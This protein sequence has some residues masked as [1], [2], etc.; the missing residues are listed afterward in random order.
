MQQLECLVTA[1]MQDSML[2]ADSAANKLPAEEAQEKAQATAKKGKKKKQTPKKLYQV[3]SAA[4]SFC[5]CLPVLECFFKSDMSILFQK[6]PIYDG[7]SN[8][9]MHIDSNNALLHWAGV[10]CLQRLM[11]AAAES[12]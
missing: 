3:A 9:E 10:L 7:N 4:Q 6:R 1:P 2:A 12:I 8:S 5:L 11:P